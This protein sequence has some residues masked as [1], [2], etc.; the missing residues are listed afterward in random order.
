MGMSSAG[1]PCLRLDSG[2]DKK[3]KQE[4]KGKGFRNLVKRIAIDT[5]GS[6]KRQKRETKRFHCKRLWLMKVC[7]IH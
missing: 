3:K 5:H 6:L 4:G 2:G 1:M 7:L